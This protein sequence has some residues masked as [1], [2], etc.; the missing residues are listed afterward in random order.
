MKDILEYKIIEAD[1]FNLTIYHVLIIIATILVTR[2][3]QLVFKK[4]LKK[5][6]SKAKI[7]AKKSNSIYQIVRYT[8]WVIAISIMLDTIGI[9]ITI[10]IASSA[11][12]L[13]GLGLGIQQIFNDIVSGV[14][15]LFEGR[16]KVGDIVE[17]DDVVGKV[18]LIGLRT[19]L[20]ET[21]DNIVMII[22]NS[23]FINENVINWS[24][25]EKK[26]RFSINVGVAYGSDVKLVE[27]ILLDCA[28]FHKDIPNEPKP[29]VRFNDFGNSSLDFQL[30]FWTHKSFRVENI[31]SDVRFTI[32]DNFKRYNIVIPFPQRDLHIKN[33]Q[34]KNEMATPKDI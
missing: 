30:F 32:N 8:L 3:L 23:R 22:P 18:K 26:T 29:F 9:N 21:R 31:K 12:L 24:H 14:F 34:T 7:D 27:H 19:S 28:S 33:S 1:N 11:A 20:V 16:L 6:S 15:L 25:I 5:T 13:V 4:L 10:L 17:L 2:I